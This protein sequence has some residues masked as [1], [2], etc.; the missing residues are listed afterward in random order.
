MTNLPSPLES[1][2]NPGKFYLTCAQT[3]T[4]VRNALKNAFPGVKFSV[5]SKTYSGGASISIHYAK[6]DLCSYRVERITS[7]F[8]GADF[9]GMVDL[10]TYNQH[11]LLPDGSVKLA[12]YHPDGMSGP[13]GVV[14]ALPEG[15]KLVHM[16]A[17]FIF[18]TNDA[19]CGHERRYDCE[20]VAKNTQ[21]VA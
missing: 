1:S 20:Q 2:C 6:P 18:V 3:A 13:V 10:K 14:Q 19:R 4:L 9:D 15:S 11:Y 21:V 7:Q 12:S 8:A 17:N 16:G 5:R